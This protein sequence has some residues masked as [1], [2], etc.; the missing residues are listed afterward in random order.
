MA[1]MA[2]RVARLNIQ[3]PFRAD[4]RMRATLSKRLCLAVRLHGQTNTHASGQ[5]NTH[6]G[7]RVEPFRSYSPHGKMNALQ[8]GR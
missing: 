5:S 2:R 3:S 1:E 6:T 4:G 7:N 8:V